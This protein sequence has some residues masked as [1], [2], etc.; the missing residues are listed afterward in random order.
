MPCRGREALAHARETTG[1]QPRGNT[2]SQNQND[3]PD[4][5]NANPGARA[6]PATM[7]FLDNDPDYDYVTSG[8]LPS[9]AEFRIRDFF[10]STASPAAHWERHI[11]SFCS[12]SSNKTFGSNFNNGAL[13]PFEDK[14]PSVIAPG[15]NRDCPSSSWLPIEVLMRNRTLAQP[16]GERVPCPHR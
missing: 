11:M 14:C 16:L 3:S 5:I 6:V 10:R 4:R 9:Q 12:E 8:R 7:A 15:L 1:H 13:L 2:N